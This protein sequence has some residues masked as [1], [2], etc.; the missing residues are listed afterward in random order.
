MDY[1]L[2]NDI[3]ARF[4]I[5]E[6]EAKRIAE[7]VDNE[8]QFVDVWENQVWWTDEH[9]A[10][11][12]RIWFRDGSTVSETWGGQNITVFD[13]PIQLIAD[14]PRFKAH[15]IITSIKELYELAQQYNFD[16]DEVLNDG[17]SQI[18]ENEEF[19]VVIGGVV[20]K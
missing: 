1:K 19:P 6:D 3:S 8:K 15:K 16:A 7:S 9:Q 2:I 13:E 14:F 17:K 11:T 10:K 12:F 18:I 4:D 5:S 20:T